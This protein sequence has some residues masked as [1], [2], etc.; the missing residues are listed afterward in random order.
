MPLLDLWKKDREELKEKNIQQVIAFAGDG[1]LSDNSSA[2][3]ELR[4]FLRN[5]PSDLLEKYVEQCLNESFQSSGF[6]LQDLVNEIGHRLDFIVKP[7]RYRGTSAQIG[8]DGIWT[9]SN[10]F[11]IIVEVKTTDTYRIYLNTIA[12]Y[13][14]SLAKSNEIKLENSSMLIIVGRQ[15]TGDIEAQ[16]RGSRHAWDMRIISIGALLRLLKLKEEVEDPS[17]LKRI[18][19]ILIPME[20]TRLDPII[21]IAFS[22]VEDVK[23]E[24]EIEEEIF[25]EGSKKIKH[26]SFHYDCIVRI[27]RHLNMTLIKQ[28]RASYASPDDKVRLICAVSRYHEIKKTYW[29]AFRQHN[30]RFL[31]QAENSFAAFGCGD[32]N[33]IF[34]IPF[35]DFKPWLEFFYKTQQMGKV[36]WHVN[37]HKKKNSYFMT[38]RSGTKDIDITKY[39]I[40]VI[41][42]A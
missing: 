31:K 28:S 2:S 7:G 38:G 30:E 10:H 32:S 6:A 5:V 40:D 25:E 3:S 12:E 17:I 13:R 1:K 18:H 20:F 29:F 33:T 42:R 19:G 27:E 14:Q 22:A 15:D 41:K 24:P 23:K 36:F 26:V 39:K 8:F 37:I 35:E 11:S 34:M 16:I 4:D 21:E 9:E